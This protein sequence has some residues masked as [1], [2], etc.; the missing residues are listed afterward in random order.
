MA[1]ASINALADGVKEAPREGS[2][3]A[4]YVGAFSGTECREHAEHARVPPLG[5]LCELSG[6]QKLGNSDIRL[7][8]TSLLLRTCA[9]T[10]FGCT[11]SA[12]VL[13]W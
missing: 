2:R 11:E 6:I 3:D 13:D 7:H 4:L 8:A 9:C 12:S 1:G 5:L 10:P